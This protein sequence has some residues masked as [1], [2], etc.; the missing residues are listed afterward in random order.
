MGTLRRGWPWIGNQQHARGPRG[1]SW[2]GRASRRRPQPDGLTTQQAV[3]ELPAW[4]EATWPLPAPA[5]QV[6]EKQGRRGGHGYG[7]PTTTSR[8]L[9]G[10]PGGCKR[11]R[12]GGLWLVLPHA[13]P[14]PPDVCC[15]LSVSHPRTRLGP[16][17][18][19]RALSSLC[20]RAPQHPP[21]CV[22]GAACDCP[23]P[24]RSWDLAESRNCHL[25]V[26]AAQMATAQKTRAHGVRERAQSGEPD[27]GRSTGARPPEDLLP[28][29]ITQ[30]LLQLT[31]PQGHPP[32][33]RHSSANAPPPSTPHHPAVLPSSA[34]TAVGSDM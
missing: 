27:A 29:N 16:H 15:A 20:P 26:S 19:F 24:T 9:P 5:P 11:S 10:A 8:G 12:D 18:L 34:V 33:P 13:H 17:S 3:A 28:A 2:A 7:C 30:R 31:P 1:A 14:Q 22:T 25:L 21:A 23:A 4:A 32:C 6:R